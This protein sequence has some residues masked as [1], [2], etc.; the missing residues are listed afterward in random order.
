[1]P[2]QQKGKT[3]LLKVTEVGRLHVSLCLHV[4][5]FGGRDS[6]CEHTVWRSIACALFAVSVIQIQGALLHLD[7]LRCLPKKRIFLAPTVYPASLFFLYSPYSW[8]LGASCLASV[9]YVV[10]LLPLAPCF[11]VFREALRPV[12]ELLQ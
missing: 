6:V 11:G 9:L 4:R 5:A 8:A 3:Q 10:S 2:L 7:L 12:A 1:M